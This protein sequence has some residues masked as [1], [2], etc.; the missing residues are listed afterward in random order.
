MW[1]FRSLSHITPQAPTLSHFQQHFL[2]G[3]RSE[4]LT[5]YEVPDIM[6]DTHPSVPVSALPAIWMMQYHSQQPTASKNLVPI[7]GVLFSNN[8]SQL[9]HSSTAAAGGSILSAA[10]VSSPHPGSVC[11]IITYPRHNKGLVGQSDF[12]IL[13]ESHV[14]LFCRWRTNMHLYP[15]RLYPN[16]C[17]IAQNVRKSSPASHRQRL[18]VHQD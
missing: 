14:D 8:F 16:F 15:G 13:A 5:R 10:V 17:L 1:S 6:T 3:T 18:K 11:I 7:S 4:F 9:P 12:N 2:P